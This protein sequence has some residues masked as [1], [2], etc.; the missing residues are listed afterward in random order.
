MAHNRE[1]KTSGTKSETCC[2]SCH[3]AHRG[4]AKFCS[5]CGH[6]LTGDGIPKLTTTPSD[7]LSGSLQIGAS[8]QRRQMTI[9]FCDLVGSTALSLQ[10]D[11]ED[12]REVIDTCHRCISK[13]ATRF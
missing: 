7:K 4:D 8:V 1:H 11:P 6:R 3:S 9:M 13:V 10:L 2:P 5:E 12:L